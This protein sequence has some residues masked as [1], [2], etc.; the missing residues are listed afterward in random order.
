MHGTLLQKLAQA[1]VGGSFW[2]SKERGHGG[3]QSALRL[4]NA[5]TEGGLNNPSSG[6]ALPLNIIGL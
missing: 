6:Q 4:P 1:C 5:A 2:A 3:F